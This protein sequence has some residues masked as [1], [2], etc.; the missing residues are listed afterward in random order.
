MLTIPPKSVQN[1]LGLFTLDD[2]AP[3]VLR[4]TC[5]RDDA[6][7]NQVVDFIGIIAQSRKDFDVVFAQVRCPLVVWL[8]VAQ[9]K[10]HPNRLEV[11]PVA[12][13]VNRDDRAIL[14]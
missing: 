2:F 7:F 9:R 8:I 6:F 5:L 1:R 11:A 14:V 4:A 10:R 12:A 13:L 3:W